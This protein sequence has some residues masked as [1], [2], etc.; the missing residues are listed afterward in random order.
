MD[1]P[2][3]VSVANARD[4]STPGVPGHLQR[5]LGFMAGQSIVWVENRQTWARNLTRCGQN[6]NL[7]VPSRVRFRPSIST[8]SKNSLSHRRIG[9]ENKAETRL[10]SPNIGGPFCQRLAVS[11]RFVTRQPTDRKRNFHRNMTP[12]SRHATVNSLVCIQRG[13][14]L[15]AK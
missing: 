6:L 10:R 2:S 9:K 11:A 12:G 7:A 5:R 3:T 4:R 8:D 13:T 1:E 15:G 14:N